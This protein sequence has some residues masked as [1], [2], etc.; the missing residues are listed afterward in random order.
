V[1]G[2]VAL[3]VTLLD[4]KHNPSID[5]QREMAAAVWAMAARNP[6]N[7]RGVAEAG[8]I[9]SLIALL[10]GPPDVHRDVAGALW[11]L[12]GNPGNPDNQQ[13]IAEAGGIVSGRLSISPR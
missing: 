2:G 11:S 5:G 4:P 3:L 7:Q 13:T 6:D 9:P 1:A 12:A 8:G 10:H